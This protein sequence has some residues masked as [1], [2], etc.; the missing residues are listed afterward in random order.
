MNYKSLWFE[1]Y[2]YST[3]F[4]LPD[5]LWCYFYKSRKSYFE[6]IGR[7]IEQN[8]TFILICSLRW[9]TTSLTRAVFWSA[10]SKVS[11][12]FQN[13][14]S[15]GN[16]PYSPYFGIYCPFPLY[17]SLSRWVGRRTSSNLEVVRS[18]DGVTN[19][20]PS[21]LEQKPP[22]VALHPPRLCLAI[23]RWKAEW[24]RRSHVNVR[25]WH[26][27]VHCFILKTLLRWRRSVRRRDRGGFEIRG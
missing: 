20:P 3:V 22:S 13:D 2:L 24:L 6:N 12:W 10:L 4:A 25:I 27:C 5:W 18:T 14:G 23:A 11:T 9:F 15:A 1:S 16:D 26:G 7:Y 8:S 19:T 21:A 17:C